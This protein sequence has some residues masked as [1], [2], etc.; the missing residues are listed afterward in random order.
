MQPEIGSTWVYTVSSSCTAKNVVFFWAHWQKNY[1][2]KT[3]ITSPCV[4]RKART[5]SWIWQKPLAKCNN[6]DVR[7]HEKFFSVSHMQ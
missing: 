5:M 3:C 7:L 4:G 2:H 1:Q 6:C